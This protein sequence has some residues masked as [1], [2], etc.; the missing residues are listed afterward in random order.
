MKTKRFNWSVANHDSMQDTMFAGMNVYERVTHA[1]SLEIQP[2]TSS[3]YPA[4]A[5]A[6]FFYA[7]QKFFKRTHLRTPPIN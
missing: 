4:H 5:H 3:V 2:L 1:A 7:R 6:H